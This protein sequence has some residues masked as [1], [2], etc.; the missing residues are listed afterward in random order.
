MVRGLC[1]FV[2]QAPENVHASKITCKIL[3]C[4]WIQAIK[5]YRTL[6]TTFSVDLLQCQQAEKHSHSPDAIKTSHSS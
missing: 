6:Y 4:F 3:F 5:E 2:L 1:I